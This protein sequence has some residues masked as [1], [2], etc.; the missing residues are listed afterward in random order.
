M[1]EY[2]KENKYLDLARELKKLWN[3]KVTVISIV[4]GAPGTV[5]KGLVKILEDLEIRGRVETIQTTALLRS[6]RILRRILET[7]RDFLSLRSKIMIIIP[8]GL[9][10]E[11][12]EL[13]IGGWAETIQTTALL[14]SAR[15][16][17]RVLDT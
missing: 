16:L 1:K 12:W 8:K 11:L 5:T 13:E 2:E 14:R 9:V 3:M 4:T 6:A 10:K 7:W 15:I 17:R